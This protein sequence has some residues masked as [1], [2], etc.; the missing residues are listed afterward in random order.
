MKIVKKKVRMKRIVMRITM[1]TK[2]KMAM[3]K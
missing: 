2:V 3:R 1:M